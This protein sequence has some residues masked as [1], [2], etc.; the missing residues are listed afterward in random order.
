MAVQM[1]YVTGGENSLYKSSV[2]G[3]SK[4]AKRGSWNSKSKGH[5]V[6]D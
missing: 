2:A 1:E 3:G 6:E 4:L 5:M